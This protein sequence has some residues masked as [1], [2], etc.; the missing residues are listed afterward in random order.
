MI[1]LDDEFFFDS[2]I[3]L[4]DGKMPQYG[5]GLSAADEKSEQ[6]RDSPPIRVQSFHQ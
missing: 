2:H 4:V 6:Q 3:F 5:Y 1:I